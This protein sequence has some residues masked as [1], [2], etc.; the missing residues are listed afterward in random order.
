V[1]DP[2]V[3]FHFSSLS[4]LLTRDNLSLQGTKPQ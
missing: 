4:P 3:D 2:V 1:N